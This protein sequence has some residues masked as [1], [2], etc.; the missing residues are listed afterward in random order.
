VAEQRAKQ[1]EADRKKAQAID[2]V[3]VVCVVCVCVSDFLLS[4]LDRERKCLPFH[5]SF[6]TRAWVSAFRSRRCRVP[7]NVQSALKTVQPK[8]WV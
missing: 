3:C 8:V 2:E 7:S 1:V 5:H 6:S 4:L